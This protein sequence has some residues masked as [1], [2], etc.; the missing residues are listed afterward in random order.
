MPSPAGLLAPMTIMRPAFLGGEAWTLSGINEV[1]V[2]LGRNGSGKSQLLKKIRDADV[3]NSYLIVAERGGDITVQHGLMNEIASPAW[4]RQRT[5]GNISGDYRSE[6]V[7]RLQS[8]LILR[9]ATE[10]K[11]ITHDLAEIFQPLSIILPDFSVQLKKENPYYTLTRLKD[12][13][14]VSAISGLSSGESQLFTIGLD[15]LTIIGM[16]KLQGRMDFRLLIDEPDAHIH[17]DLQVKFADFLIALN[18]EYSFPIFIATH[19]TSLLSALGLF[20]GNK[21]SVFNISPVASNLVGEAF[22]SVK[23]QLTAM[24][25]GHLILGPLF[26]APLL[27]VEGDDDY[28]VWLHA[29]RGGQM[30]ISVM[31][32]NGD[33][34][35][36]YQSTLE[37]MFS[38]LSENQTLRA[39]VLIDGDKNR[40]QASPTKPQNYT[41]YFQ[42]NC[43]ETENLYLSDEVLRELGYEGWPQALQKIVNEAPKYGASQAALLE[44]QGID[45]RTADIKS[46]IHQLAQILDSK[47]VLWAV[48]VGKLLGKQKPTG[49]LQDFIGAAFC[50]VL[51]P[52]P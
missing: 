18:K 51:W 22:N 40:P 10:N 32:C 50:E 52:T 14:Q 49:M 25:G 23:K 27:L 31:P 16:K 3:E 39:Y 48:R 24:L 9:G 21:V 43:H 47:N 13:S 37:K 11:D 4:Q 36:E 19:S 29:A 30:N 44:L 38:S 5:E 8:Y 33:E 12:N 6:V 1:N 41:Q 28:R 35:F 42:L 26:S 46:V 34:I 2:L 7:T 17:Q 45:R 20:G 15:I